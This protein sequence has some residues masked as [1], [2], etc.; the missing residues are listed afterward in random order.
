MSYPKIE[1]SYPK[2]EDAF[3]Q[4]LHTVLNG[5]RINASEWVMFE[6]AKVFLRVS[7]RRL[8]FR[9]DVF[10]GKREYCVDIA[11]ILVP[12]HFQKQGCFNRL[13]AY[14]HANCI[15]PVFVENILRPDWYDHLVKNGWVPHTTDCVFRRRSSFKYYPKYWGGQY[16]TNSDW[17]VA[18]SYNDQ[19][20]PANSVFYKIIFLTWSESEA[21][22]LANSLNSAGAMLDPA[23]LKVF[24][25]QDL[26]PAGMRQFAI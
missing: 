11:T 18:C 9:S 1:E 17:G 7:Q 26:P 20:E 23:L 16:G 3:P 24:A 13:V 5:D 15:L 4:M 6:H 25:T 8:M 19:I 2:I 14:I 21:Q 10:E 22:A 12:K